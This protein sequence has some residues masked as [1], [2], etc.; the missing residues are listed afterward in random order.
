MAATL[1]LAELDE[2][3]RIESV[4]SDGAH[5]DGA[6]GGGPWVAVLVGGGR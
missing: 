6:A 5:P 2:L 3:L 4:S 1:H